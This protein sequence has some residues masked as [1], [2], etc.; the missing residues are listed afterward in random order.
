MTVLISGCTRENIHVNAVQWLLGEQR[1]G[2]SVDLVNSL[3][4]IDWNRNQ[5][6]WRFLKSKHS[7][8]FI[9]DSD[10]VPASGTIEVLLSH[11]KDAIIAPNFGL[12]QPET[13]K[14]AVRKMAWTDVGG[15][16]NP[17]PQGWVDLIELPQRIF[18]SG[19]SGLL[20]KREVLEAIANPWF[21]FLYDLEGKIMLSED[22]FFFRKV[23][24]AGFDL[25]ADWTL[26]QHHFKTVDLKFLYDEQIDRGTDD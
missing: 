2:H 4:P 6:V 5:Q 22:I 12:A 23:H 11:D 16:D 25:W 14:L 8:M 26:P 10:A 24:A 18:S 3:E 21:R 9:F 15:D 20:V 13:G 19:M 7:H 17:N 1:R